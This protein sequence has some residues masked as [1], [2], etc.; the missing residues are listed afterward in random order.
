MTLYSEGPRNARIVLVGEAPGSNEVTLKRPFVGYSGELLDKMLSRAGIRRDQVFITN[1]AHVQPPGNDF[2][3][4]YKGGKEHLF[5]GIL[6]LKKDLDEIK[7]NI[8]CA[9]GAYPARILTNKKGITSWRGSILPCTLVPG[10]KVVSTFHPAAILRTPDYKVV[11]EF[12]LKRVAEESLFP[13]LVYP[14]RDLILD[15]DPAVLED[16]VVELLK[17]E[18]LAVDIECVQRADKSWRLSCVGFSDKA[19]RAVTIPCDSAVKLAAIRILLESPVKKVMQNG[20]FDTTVLRDE[21]FVVNNFAYDTMIGHHALFAEC[22]N[23]EDEMSKHSKKKRSAALAKGLAFQTSIY[24][25]EP[26]YKDDGKLWQDTGDYQMFWRYNSL[27]AAVTREILD[28]Q[29]KE[30][31]SMGNYHVLEHGM[32]LVEPLM[33]MTSCGI[34]VDLPRRAAIRKQLEEEIDNFQNFLDAGAG[35]PINVSSPD[36]KWLLYDKLKLP[37]K[38]NKKTRAVTADK[39]AIIALAKSHPDPLLHT[40]LEIRQRR[41]LIETYLDAAVDSDGRMRCSFDITGTRSGR[42]S[43][44]ASIYGSGTNLQTI[45]EDMREMFVADEGR[46][47][48]YRDLSQAEARVV[49]ALA[50]DE[51]LLELFADPTRD[52]HK[53][54]ASRIFN[55]PISEVTDAQ[56][57]LGKRV[58][59]AVN[60]GMDAKRFVEVVNEDAK[61]TGISI[62]ESLARSVIDGFWLLHPNHKSV[63]WATIERQVKHSRSLSTPFGRKRLFFGRMDDKLFREAYSYIPQSTV[64]WICNEGVARIYNRIGL[65]RPDLRAQLLLQVHDSILVQCPREHAREVAALMG[66]CMTIPFECNGHKLVIPTDAKIGYNW[67]NRSK[68]GKT[69]PAGLRDISKWEDS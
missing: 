44:R 28:V 61:T 22:A 9:L 1:V 17:A 21:G 34:K 11:T 47:F 69:N 5:R 36:V 60:Y 4:F 10:L 29:V 14:K 18:W 57:Y 59:H 51:Y 55:V 58:R 49:A 16:L 31:N 12:D 63:Y 41:K 30:L 24:T 15:P 67:G 32:S 42:L 64:G 53:E 35:K 46:V 39:D 48:I 26:R 7:P 66:E 27:D 52:I 54:T 68:D 23:G 65:G 45:P 8:V 19:E 50:N 37:K 38:I 56:R 13:E 33:S 62:T 43:S 2:A 3:W 20:M 40:V 6:Q 25:R